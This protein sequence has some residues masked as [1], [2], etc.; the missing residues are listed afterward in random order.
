[1][2][3]QACPHEAVQEADEDGRSYHHHEVIQYGTVY[4]K[5][6]QLGL[7]LAVLEASSLTSTRRPWILPSSFSL[8]R[9][10]LLVNVAMTTRTFH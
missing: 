4:E 10:V 6:P 8:A 3:A 9:R 5:H 7:R 2:L 1:M